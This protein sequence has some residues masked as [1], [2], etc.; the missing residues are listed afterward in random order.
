[1]ATQQESVAIWAI[2]SLGP[3]AVVEEGVVVVVVVGQILV[4]LDSHTSHSQAS[5]SVAEERRLRRAHLVSDR[6]LCRQ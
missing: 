3:V 1:M 2:A 6:R 5:H 4:C